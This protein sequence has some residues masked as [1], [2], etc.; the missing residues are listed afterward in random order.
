MMTR[1]IVT[2]VRNPPIA[3]TAKVK[4]RPMSDGRNTR[5]RAITARI[6]TM[7]ISRKM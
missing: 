3:M 4:G 2:A 5:Q 6:P 1:K 7:E